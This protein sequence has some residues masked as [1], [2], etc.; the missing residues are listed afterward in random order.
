MFL[1][2]GGAGFIGSNIIASLNDSGIQDIIINDI[3]H[4]DD[5]KWNN[6]KKRSYLDIIPPS[7]LMR[8]LAEKKLEAVIHMGAISDTTETNQA[9][10]TENNLH[11]SIQLLEWCIENNTPFIYASSAATYG[12]GE[13]GFNDDWSLQYLDKLEPLN[14]Y[15]KSKHDFDIYVAKKYFNNLPL[16]PRWVGLKFFNVY[17]P[18]EYH[19]GQMMSIIP[20]VFD[21]AKMGQTIKLFKSHKFGISH[22][23]Q[24]RDFIYIDDVISVLRWFLDESKVNGIYNVGTGQAGSFQEL[25]KALFASLDLS[26]KI[27]YVDMPFSIR[28]QYQYFTQSN[29]ENL[30]KAGY[31][32][33][34]LPLQESMDRYVKNFLNTD[35]KYR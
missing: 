21:I 25:I 24:R 19:K 31:N 32:Q 26:E 4:T 10:L 8:F 28:N 23:D 18:N 30:R 29:I 13:Y 22:G 6:L 7:H 34:F 3:L 20:K 12:N 14:L 17:G 35:N 27:E 15:G 33:A 2:T 5:L 1:V 16:P 11:L 9:A